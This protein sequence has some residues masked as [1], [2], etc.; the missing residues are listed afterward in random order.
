MAHS[1]LSCLAF[2]VCQNIPGVTLSLTKRHLYIVPVWNTAVVFRKHLCLFHVVHVFSKSRPVNADV[3]EIRQA[4]GASALFQDGSLQLSVVARIH[5]K[6][7]SQC[8][9][10]WEQDLKDI[11]GR[12]MGS[13]LSIHDIMVPFSSHLSNFVFWVQ[14]L[15]CKHEHFNCC[16]STI[17]V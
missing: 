2:I 5:K 9:S 6:E 8:Y 15:W 16:K 1:R 11:S 14:L 7:K 12:W 4:T 3:E 10:V 17:N 13:L